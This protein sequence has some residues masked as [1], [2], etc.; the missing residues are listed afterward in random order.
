MDP[1]CDPDT[2]QIMTQDQGGKKII[3]HIRGG[4]SSYYYLSI[5][6][7]ESKRKCSKEVLSSETAKRMINL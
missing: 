4:Q 2:S 3:K 1:N 5:T 6:R 7:Q